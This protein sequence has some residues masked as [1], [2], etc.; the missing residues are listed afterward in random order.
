MTLR[1]IQLSA[2]ESHWRLFSIRKS[3]SK[4]QAFQTRIFER[5]EYTCQFCGFCAHELMDVVNLD[6]NYRNNHIDN[7]VTACHFCSQCFFLDGVG[8]GDFG[9][10]V[11]IY[12]PEMPQNELNAFC[13]VLFSLMIS[14]GRS[15]AEA[16]TIYRNLRLRTQYVEKELGKGLSDPST[17]G[18]LLIDADINNKSE[19][20]QMLIEK[21][22]VLPIISSYV[23]QLH[24]WADS[25]LKKMSELV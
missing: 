19:L 15:A 13:H 18:Q 5:D 12:L 20:H 25:A 17:Y 14:G 9:G 1:D 16:K 22:R 24:V 8:K 2:T 7:L 4:F 10:G 21:L 11:L 23:S 6:G 3:D